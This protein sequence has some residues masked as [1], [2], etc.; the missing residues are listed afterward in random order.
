MSGG[1][2]AKAPGMYIPD[3]FQLKKAAVSI[4]ISD[5]FQKGRGALMS[6][7]RATAVCRPVKQSYTTRRRPRWAA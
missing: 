7:L 1:A 6:T 4:E 2:L 5:A 3:T